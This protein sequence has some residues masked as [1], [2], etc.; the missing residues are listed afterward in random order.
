MSK[1]SNRSMPQRRRELVHRRVGASVVLLD[2]GTNEAMALE[3]AVA[4]VW[5]ACDGAAN[6]EV[7][8][9]QTGLT[10]EQVSGAL[11]ALST[12]GL[13]EPVRS[14]QLKAI[15]R[16]AVLGA[17]AGVGAALITSVVLPTPAMAS[18]GQAGA[19][20][21]NKP[22]LNNSAAPLSS[23]SAGS[24]TTTNTTGEAQRSHLTTSQPHS[25]GALAFTGLD[26]R[27]DVAVAAGLI[28]AGVT[29]VAANRRGAAKR[30]LSQNDPQ[31]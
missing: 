16:R 11:A 21:T 9:E 22:V 30:S 20:N 19:P 8:A 10:A 28:A 2:P 15:S 17:G 26:P 12:A 24:P 3:P 25:S 1:R 23:A 18:S 14:D 6:P 31:E 7:V 27:D 4:V 5:M 13:L 29:I